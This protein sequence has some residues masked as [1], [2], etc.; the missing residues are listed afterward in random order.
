MI[1]VAGAF[2]AFSIT[3]PCHADERPAKPTD[4]IPSWK[5]AFDS[6]MLAY[7]YPG[8][9]APQTREYPFVAPEKRAP[10][11]QD[12]KIC[13][14]ATEA[15]ELVRILE[16]AAK[17]EVELEMTVKALDDANKRI[18]FLEAEAYETNRDMQALATRYLQLQD[19]L[20]KANQTIDSL[21]N[22][23]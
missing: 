17:Q 8:W 6:P 10:E 4:S 5:E 2:A 23:R 16:N 20:N 21:T 12:Q 7:A 13:I 18:N 14:T 9:T 11:E 3:A 15:R 22:P 1:L 19:E